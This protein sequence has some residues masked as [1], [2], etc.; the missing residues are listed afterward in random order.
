MI[1]QVDEDHQKCI[2]MYLEI[3]KKLKNVEN[4]NKSYQQAIELY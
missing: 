3:I 1:I 4:T 2:N